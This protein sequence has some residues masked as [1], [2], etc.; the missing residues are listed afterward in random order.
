MTSHWTIYWLVGPEGPRYI[1]KTKRRLSSRLSEHLRN[2]RNGERTHKARWVGS[3]LASGGV[4]SIE[5]VASAADNDAANAVEAAVIA[6]L[7][8][9]CRL[10]NGTTG[11]DGGSGRVVSAKERATLSAR[12]RGVV[13]SE[14]TRR[15]IGLSSIGREAS[16]ETRAKLSA[17]HKGRP[18]SE[19]HRASMSAAMGRRGPEFRARLSLAKRNISEATRAKMRAAASRREAHRRAQRQGA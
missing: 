15:L 8:G 1:G 7:A 9:S 16:P 13:A 6:R 17:A 4:V 3:V 10:T 14:E 5:G 2:A 18:K 12:R 19:A 11:G